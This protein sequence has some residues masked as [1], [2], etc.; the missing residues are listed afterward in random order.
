MSLFIMWKRLANWAI[1]LA[2][3]AGSL[4]YLVHKVDLAAAWQAG[5]GLSVWFCAAAFALQVVQIAICAL[6]WQ[7]V[8]RAI[9]ARMPFLRA[10]G[11]FMIGNFFGQIL[12]GA[13]GGDAVRVLATRRAGLDFGH[14][15]NSVMLERAATVYALVLLTTLAEPAMLQ[16]LSDAP[17]LWLFPGLT[18]GATIGLVLLAELD[19]LPFSWR[20]WKLVRAFVQLA[21]DTRACFLKPGNAVRILAIALFGHVNLAILMWVLALGIGAPVG[22]VD[23]LVLVPPVILVATLPISIAGW[24]AREVAMI[25][26]FG[27]IGVPAAQATAISVLFGLSTMLI[28]LPGG[29]L[30]LLE[31]REIPG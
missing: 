6:R 2:L 29:V 30:L 3:T 21:A 12:P 15:I 25:T 22:V 17:G 19:R 11:L 8:L 27:L 23:C 24:G 18:V 13:V 31:R 5:K 28:A 9:R 7:A 10:A 20:R 14:A 26:V 1:K 16:R 4:A